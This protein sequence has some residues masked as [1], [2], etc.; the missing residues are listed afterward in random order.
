MPGSALPPRSIFFHDGFLTVNASETGS[1]SLAGQSGSPRWRL[2]AAAGAVAIVLLMIVLRPGCIRQQSRDLSA[3]LSQQLE[4]Q[5]TKTDDL[6]SAMRYLRQI[7]P[8]TRDVVARE[9]RLELNTWLQ[10]VDLGQAAFTPSPLLDDLPRDMLETVGCR[11]PLELTFSYWDVDYLY[12][13]YMMNALSGWVVDF[14]L[15]D[16]LVARMLEPVR[17]ELEPEEALKLEEA[18]KLFDWTTRNIALDP[19]GSSVEQL[20]LDPQPPLVDGAPGYRN[21]PWESLLYSYADAIERGR[22]F[23]SLCQQRGIETYWVAVHAERPPSQIWAVAALIGDRLWLFEPRL[24][25]PI[26]DPDALRLATLRDALE[27]PR[28]LRRLDLP[29]RFDYGLDPGATGEIEL[30]IDVPPTAA[31][32]RMK[33]LEQSLLGDERMVLYRDLERAQQLASQIAPSASVR[34][35]QVPLMAQ[36]QA[37]SVRD[38]LQR[39]S[40]FTLNYF[41]M[42]G[43]WMMENPAAEGRLKHLFGQFE[44]TM[45]GRGAL[46]LYMDSRIDDERIQKLAYD[47]DVQRE[48][49]FTRRSGEELEQFQ[50]RL[51]QAQIVLRQAKVDAAYLMAQLHFDRGNYSAA[52]NW[53]LKRVINS[54]DP[55]AQKW[56]AISHYALARVYQELSKLDDAAEHLT[57]QPSPQEAGNRLRLRYLRAIADGQGAADAPNQATPQP[58][59][60]DREDPASDEANPDAP[61]G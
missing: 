29:G 17:D 44:N 11:T 16:S 25:M 2:A 5:K 49:G 51:Q 36:V 56:H 50:T 42:H 54:P 18:C 8:M 30:L 31:S 13:C 20:V 15:R 46:S 52:E 35:W 47:P 60:T 6:R 24:A 14:P 26:V 9:V 21:L 48:L 27:N 57:W 45:D 40:D 23:T 32:A 59:D 37:A 28:V 55:R 3:A 53:F 34:L 1:K 12:Q 38:R 43:V 7:T 19:P 33:L 22:V 41:A 58:P 61:R 10:G 4:E 39:M